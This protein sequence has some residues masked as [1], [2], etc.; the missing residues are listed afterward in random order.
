VKS[1]LNIALT[2]LTNQLTHVL[3][4]IALNLNN[5]EN[6]NVLTVKQVPNR[7]KDS[8]FDSFSHPLNH[9]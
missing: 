6:A 5:T 2:I 1:C 4:A 9:I 8:N 7:H 3:L